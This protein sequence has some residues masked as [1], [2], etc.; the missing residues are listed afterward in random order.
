MK[1]TP[2]P[3]SVLRVIA[4]AMNLLVLIPYGLFIVAVAFSGDYD[5]GFPLLGGLAIVASGGLN[6]LSLRL[7]FRGTARTSARA[8]AAVFNVGLIA[9][10]SL[11]WLDRPAL[12]GIVEH[13][14]FALPKLLVP[15]LTL[16]ALGLMKPYWNEPLCRQCGYDLR[17]S[18]G[19]RCPECGQERA[20]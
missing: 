20:R 17:G 9:T 10:A 2:V 12:I 4:G 7:M 6:L 15:A 5:P 18:S 19:P 13:T 1:E 11:E 16:L 8:L 14:L 3:L